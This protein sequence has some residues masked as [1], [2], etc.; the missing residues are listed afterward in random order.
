MISTREPVT[1]VKLFH[2]SRETFAPKG[3]DKA[4]ALCPKGTPE[5][6]GPLIFAANLANI[7]IDT[8]RFSCSGMKVY[9]LLIVPAFPLD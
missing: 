9:K 8:K 3:K 1:Y 4:G 6:T 5:I 7:H 2:I